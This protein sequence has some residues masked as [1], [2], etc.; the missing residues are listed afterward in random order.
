[1]YQTWADIRTSV[2]MC[3]GKISCETFVFFQS[4]INVELCLDFFISEVKVRTAR[5]R[6]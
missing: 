6:S 1:M 5:A 3:W 2:N 4:K